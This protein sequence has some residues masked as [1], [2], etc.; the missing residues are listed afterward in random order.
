M[1]YSFQSIVAYRADAEHGHIVAVAQL[2]SL[3]H[4]NGFE[5]T[6]PVVENTAITGLA[7]NEGAHVLLLG[8]EHQSAQLM[9]VHG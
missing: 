7:D 4:R 6:L 3:S 2:A 5:R 1:F 9:L 8:R